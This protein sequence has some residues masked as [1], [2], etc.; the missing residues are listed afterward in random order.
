MK[1]G[2]NNF[3]YKILLWIGIYNAVLRFHYL[4]SV[5][6]NP[7]C[8]IGY[9]TF[10]ENSGRHISLFIYTQRLVVFACT[11]VCAIKMLT[12]TAFLI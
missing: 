12:Y 4:A 10:M 2:K 5:T 7:S 9:I 8:Q 6:L 11:N 1:N 3:L